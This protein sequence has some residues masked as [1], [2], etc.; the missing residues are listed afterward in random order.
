MLSDCVRLHIL[1]EHCSTASCQSFSMPWMPNFSE[2]VPSLEGISETYY[3]PHSDKESFDQNGRRYIRKVWKNRSVRRIWQVCWFLS[4]RTKH[5]H[6]ICWDELA[7]DLNK[8]AQPSESICRSC[9]HKSNS[10]TVD[11]CTLDLK[12]YVV[13]IINHYNKDIPF[14]PFDPLRRK[15]WHDKSV[16]HTRPPQTSHADGS[17]IYKHIQTKLASWRFLDDMHKTG[18]ETLPFCISIFILYY[19]IYYYRLCFLETSWFSTD[20][21]SS[22]P[23]GNFMVGICGE[24]LSH[25]WCCFRPQPKRVNKEKQHWQKDVGEGETAQ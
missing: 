14:D 9:E 25:S 8:P 16:V 4:P 3:R 17:K 15:G 18:S 1:P 11:S 19:I 22:M 12:S 7:L 23:Y 2:P 5:H 20:A 21:A 13:Y 10:S 24:T 6:V